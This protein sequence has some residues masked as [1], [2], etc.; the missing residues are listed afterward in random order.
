MVRKMV[1]K[2]SLSCLAVFMP[3]FVCVANIFG[4]DEA[5]LDKIPRLECRQAAMLHQANQLVV[6]DVHTDVKK[7]PVVGAY[8]LP[9]GKIDKVKLNFPKTQPIA[10]F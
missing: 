3:V 8:A 9:V 4:G 10:C 6:I 7:T 2:I 5:N 1:R